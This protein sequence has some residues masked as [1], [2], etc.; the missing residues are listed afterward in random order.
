MS[1][2][3]QFNEEQFISQCSKGNLELAEKKLK[4]DNVDINC[5]EK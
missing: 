5:K 2:T 1:A 4:K 3:Q